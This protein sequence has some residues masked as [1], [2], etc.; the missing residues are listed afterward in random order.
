MRKQVITNNFS[1][2][3][4]SY[5]QTA[6]MQKELADQLLLK[7]DGM[8]IAPEKVL[9]LGCGTGYLAAKLAERFPR[10]DVVGIDIAPGMIAVAENKKQQNNLSFRVGDVEEID[11]S[12]QHFQLVVANAALHWMDTP[13]V[14]KKVKE[15]LTA[16]GIFVFNT[17]GP[18][19]LKELKIS[20]F[21]VNDFMTCD[22]ILS[23]A[24]QHFYKID[25]KLYLMVVEFP[26]VRELVKQLNSL[27]A[28]S[29]QPAINSN[30]FRSMRKYREHFSLGSSIYASYEI[31]T[32]TLAV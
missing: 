1:N 2:S 20:G 5:D 7:I 24:A 12:G 17:F 9:D 31:I 10:A 16:G 26:G 22:E 32:G 15:I 30:V 29:P 19:T 4:G 27:G 18:E 14:I 3:A 8:R 21:K 6:T 13:K 11:L 25:L 23:A 28:Q